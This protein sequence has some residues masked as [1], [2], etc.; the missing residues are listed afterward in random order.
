[1][2]DSWASVASPPV[3]L[4]QGHICTNTHPEH[5]PEHSK[6]RV[7]MCCSR[8]CFPAPCPELLS[9]VTKEHSRVT[10]PG[11]GSQHSPTLGLPSVIRARQSLFARIP[12]LMKPR[13]WKETNRSTCPALYGPL[14]TSSKYSEHFKGKS[15]SPT[16]QFSPCLTTSSVDARVAQRLST[17][18]QPRA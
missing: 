11:V 4:G 5:S 6:P 9:L 8:S 3:H 16:R 10:R 18:L 12:S 7:H 17:R 2:G 15:H 14:S 1:M 13:R